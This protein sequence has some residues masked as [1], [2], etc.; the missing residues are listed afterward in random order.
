MKVKIYK[1]EDLTSVDKTG[2]FCARCLNGWYRNDRVCNNV[3]PGIQ[4]DML[5]ICRNNDNF[6]DATYY[7]R[8]KKV[9][10]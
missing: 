9:K 1:P 2:N 4:C 5:G 8:E 7:V 3:L 10:F 6:N